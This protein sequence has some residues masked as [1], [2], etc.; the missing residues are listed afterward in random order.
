MMLAGVCAFLRITAKNFRIFP[1][2][3]NANNV[4][5]QMAVKQPVGADFS[6]YA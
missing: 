4:S 3:T 1:L 2:N 6:A 5:L